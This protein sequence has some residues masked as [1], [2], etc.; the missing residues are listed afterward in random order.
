VRG[1]GSGAGLGNSG[2]A[3]AD[4]QS[5]QNPGILEEILGLLIP[6]PSAC[7]VTAWAQ[8]SCRASTPPPLGAACGYHSPACL[9]SPTLSGHSPPPQAFSLPSLFRGDVPT[10]GPLPWKSLLSGSLAEHPSLMLPPEPTSWSL[11]DRCCDFFLCCLSRPPRYAQPGAP[12]CRPGVPG[13]SPSLEFTS[14]GLTRLRGTP[15]TGRKKRAW[16]GSL[17]AP[18]AGQTFPEARGLGG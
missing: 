17:E 6:S 14:L 11:E 8:M 2:W 15:S 9:P 5:L 4:P 18:R 7:E 13:D 3:P 16:R 10:P 12:N 1:Q